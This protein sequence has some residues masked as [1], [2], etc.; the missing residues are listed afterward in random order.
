M[1]L[2]TVKEHKRSMMMKV[3]RANEAADIE[4]FGI[5]TPG[6]FKSPSN[7]TVTLFL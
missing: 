4:P 7:G 6:F 5:A 3:A 2:D 1:H